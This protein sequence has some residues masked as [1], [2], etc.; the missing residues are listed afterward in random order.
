MEPE[1]EANHDFVEDGHAAM[2]ESKYEQAAKHYWQAVKSNTDDPEIW[3]SLSRA[4]Y[5]YKKLKKAEM[6]ALE[7]A[8]RNPKN[9]TY[10]IHFLKIVRDSG[11]PENYLQ[12]LQ[13]AR[14]LF[15]DEPYVILALASGYETV[16]GDQRAARILF[17]EF[18]EKHPTHSM[19]SEAE[20]A[21]HRLTP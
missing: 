2:Q 6:M 20:E 15:P 9:P 18:L 1:T 8:R 11:D 10:I 17:K 19:R 4:F 3:F 12:E 5:Y 16:E 7:A 14:K 21:L 13:R